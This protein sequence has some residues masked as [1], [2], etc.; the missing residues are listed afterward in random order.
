MPN[1]IYSN[2]YL[3]NEIAD[4]LDSRLNLAG[5][6][7]IDNSLVAAPGLTV[8]INRYSATSGTEKLAMGAGNTK[9]ISTV[10]VPANYN[11]ALA[12]TR[13]EYFDEEAQTDPVAIRTGILMAAADMYN[14]MQGD[15]IGEMESATSMTVTAFD[16]AAFVDGVAALN[17]DDGDPTVRVNAFVNPVTAAKVRKALGTSLQYVE[18]YARQGGYIGTVAGVNVYTRRGMTSDK[19]AINTS[20]AVTVFQ[21][22]GVEVEQITNGNR[23]AADANIRKN[24]V[25][26]RRQYVAALTDTTKARVLSL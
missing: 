16:F 9:S 11:V 15:I 18:A 22:K 13:F 19:V 8:K 25:F 4:A 2:F 10:L 21:K 20:D 5:F 14:V 6:C 7:K 23:D 12:Q 1:Q 24:T 17:F 3:Q 26:A